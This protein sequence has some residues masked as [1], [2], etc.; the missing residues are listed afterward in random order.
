M[1]GAWAWAWVSPVFVTWN[2][3]SFVYDE[4]DASIDYTEEGKEVDEDDEDVSLRGCIGTFAP[5]RLEDGLREYAITAW[6][7]LG[8]FGLELVYSDGGWL[9][10]SRSAFKDTRFSPITKDE[11]P[12]LQCG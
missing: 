10:V 4:K 6:V 7:Q 8:G 9:D 5:M 2:K 1:L 3:R 11:L 12:F